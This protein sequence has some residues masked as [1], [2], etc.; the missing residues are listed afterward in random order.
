M[1]TIN[2]LDDF[3][4]ALDANPTWREAVRARILG[5]ELLQLPTRFG[6]FAQEQAAFNDEQRAIT[7]ELKA[8]NEEQKV[9][10]R[11]IMKSD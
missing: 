11:A 5:E 10:N 9:F 3:L 8:F 4:Q 7:A 6:V 2:S 1:T